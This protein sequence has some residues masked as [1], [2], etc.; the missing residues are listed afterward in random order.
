MNKTL[1][2][3]T[4]KQRFSFKNIIL[5]FKISSNV[6]SATMEIYI[7]IYVYIHTYKVS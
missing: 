1:R 6:N 4:A 7:Y 3:L 5:L 2:D